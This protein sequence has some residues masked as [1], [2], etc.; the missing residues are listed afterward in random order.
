VKWNHAT[1]ERVWQLLAGTA[2]AYLAGAILRARPGR[3][4][5]AATLTACLGAAVM[6]LKFDRQLVALGLLTEAELFYLAGVCFG[7]SYLRQLAAGLF[8]L[9][10]GHLAIVELPGVAVRAWTP[11][12]ALDALVYYANRAMIRTDV[13]YGYCGAAMLA[14]VAG[15]EAQPAYLGRI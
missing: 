7:A 11:I 2:V 13:A 9:E 8:A 1:P 10:V 5:G 12:A 4:R 6:L 14:L 15:Y 3:W